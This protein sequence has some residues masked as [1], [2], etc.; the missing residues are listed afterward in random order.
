MGRSLTYLG[1]FLGVLCAVGGVAA[2]T[3]VLTG[4]GRVKA[5]ADMVADLDRAD[6]DINAEAISNG[7]VDLKSPKR[8]EQRRA[9]KGWKGTTHHISGAST[10]DSQ[11]EYDDDDDDNNMAYSPRPL[12]CQV[13]GGGAR[14]GPPLHECSH[15]ILGDHVLDLLQRVI[16]PA[17]RATRAHGPGALTAAAVAEQVRALRSLAAPGIRLIVG[18]RALDVENSYL[19][20]WS[21]RSSLAASVNLAY[22]WVSRAGLDGIALTNLVV[23]RHTINIYAEF[24]KVSS[25]NKIRRLALPRD[26]TCV[27]MGLG[28]I[29]FLLYDRP[30]RLGQVCHNYFAEAYSTHCREWTEIRF[31]HG[32]LANTALVHRRAMAVAE[33]MDSF[34]NETTI[35]AK[36]WAALFHWNAAC[37]ALYNVELDDAGGACDSQTPYA[38]LSAVATVMRQFTTTRQTRAATTTS[39]TSP[40][41]TISQTRARVLK[42]AS[43]RVRRRRHH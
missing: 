18:L 24:L 35:A 38:R 37:L 12:L 26:Q 36:V 39:A 25:L 32:A 29:R 17:G 43:V 2:T 40:S 6:S 30:R 20:L 13:Q 22:E 23:G 33:I 16:R 27:S 41:T 42:R 31:E 1:T 14:A 7:D 10:I 19:R 11:T 21:N 28:V 15:L 8:P 34:D 9:W 5:A 4:G 3:F